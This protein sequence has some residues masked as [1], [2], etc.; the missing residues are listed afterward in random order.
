MNKATSPQ[1]IKIQGIDI[2]IRKN[3]KAK[4]L[5]IAVKPF[6]GVRITIPDRVSFDTAV[7]FA[8]EKI[9]WIREHLEKMRGF[10]KPDFFF[11]ENSEFHTRNHKLEIKKIDISRITVKVVKERI[12]LHIPLSKNINSLEVQNAVRK[13]ILKA[14]TE[15]AKEYLPKRLNDFSDKFNLPFNEVFIKNIK[16]R[17]G[18]CSGKNNIN[19]SLHLMRLPDHLIDYVLLHELAHTKVKNHSKKYW[20][21]LNEL[22]VNGKRLDKELNHFRIGLF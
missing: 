2:T 16:S 8:F 4:H 12:I 19:L 21:F 13:G 17:W 20:T 22:I 7:K 6:Q 10:E 3:A 15:E 18:S 14:Y 11:N 5:K 1:F 9:D